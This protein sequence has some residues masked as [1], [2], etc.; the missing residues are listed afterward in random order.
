MLYLGG[1]ENV[2]S[3]PEKV[4]PFSVFREIWLQSLEAGLLLS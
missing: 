2:K 3:S 1:P 4:L